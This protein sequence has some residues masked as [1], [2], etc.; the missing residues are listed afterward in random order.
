MLFQLFRKPSNPFEAATT[1][2]EYAA[3]KDQFNNLL[4]E[5]Q[6][7]IL[8]FLA[9]KANA[10]EAFAALNEIKD[11]ANFPDAVISKLNFFRDEEQDRIA[12]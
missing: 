1:K 9:A 12:W 8:S 7:A 6:E 3:Y 10:A 2:N 4:P 5:H 11:S